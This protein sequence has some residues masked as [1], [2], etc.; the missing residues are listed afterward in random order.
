MGTKTEIEKNFNILR[1]LRI[2]IHFQ[3]LLYILT[4]DNIQE[5][6][7]FSSYLHDAVIIAYFT[8]TARSRPPGI[9]LCKSTWLYGTMK[10]Y[11]NWN[12]VRLK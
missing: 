12:K 4:V 7:E 9:L 2:L 6:E 1:Y 10:I 11:L 8:F 5:D 3:R